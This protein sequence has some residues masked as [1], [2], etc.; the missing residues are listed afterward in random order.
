M[1][2][3]EWI[4]KKAVVNHHREVPYHLLKCDRELSVGDP[5]SGNLL[6]QSDNLLALKALLPYYAGRVKCIYIDPPYNTGDESWKYSDNVNSPEIRYWL[7]QT[8]GD[9]ATDLTRHDKWLC[10]M[11]PRLRLLG[12]FLKD[13]GSIWVSIDDTEF[14][15][16]RGLMDEIF[17]P[18]NFVAVNV[19][20]KRYSRENR[21][22]IGD[23]HEYVVVYSNNPGLFK[24]TRNLVPPDEKQTK[25]YK[26]SN[27]DPRGRWRPIPMTAQEGHATKDQFYEIVAPSGRVFRPP[28][29]RCW[30][31]SKK[32]FE[33]LRAEGRI[34]FGK[35]GDSQPN[36]IRYLSEIEGFV[37]WS[38]WPHDDVGHTDEAKKEIHALLGKDSAFETPKPVRLVRRILEIATKPG[39]LILDSFAGSGTTGHAVMALNKADGRNRRFILVEMDE[40]ISKRVTAQR[41]TRA[42]NGYGDTPG[43]GGGFRYCRLGEPLFDEAGNIR[44]SVTFPDL[45]AHVFFTETGGPIPKKATG[46]TPLLG[47]SNGRAV[48][49]L[50]NGVMGDKSPDSGNVLT[51]EVLRKLPAHDGLKVIYG[52]G[53]RLGPERLKREVIV[54]K[55]IPYEIKTT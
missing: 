10:M 35:R 50:F 37:P 14:Q 29:G 19:W 22:T 1:P 44:E 9:D 2:T 32:T 40:D 47:S 17:G 24:E 53:C 49:L 46:K 11:Y 18:R 7:N 55:Q 3:L 30:S 20:Q 42:I 52:E 16:L 26:N 34:Y 4:G 21:E 54:F 27:N 45:A 13:G 5:D 15:H 28:K 51:G 39:D 25:V 31:L 23:V 41:L 48:Y 38:W 33:K 8:V 36:V 43:L 6:V 12:D